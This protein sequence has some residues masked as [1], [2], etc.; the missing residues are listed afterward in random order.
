MIVGKAPVITRKSQQTPRP[1]MDCGEV[2]TPQRATQ[3]KFC[4]TDCKYRY[5]RRN[6]RGIKQGYIW[7][8]PDV[9]KYPDPMQYPGVA[10]DGRILEH[11]FIMQ[12]YLGRSL[13]EI[14]TIHHLN[15]QK[16]DNRIENLE[17]RIGNHGKGWINQDGICPC[18]KRPL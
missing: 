13:L 10:N 11:R 9:D 14:E 18:C 2:F 16:D 7:I 1:C 4:C 17:L 8:Y 15:G 12:E 3:G 5:G 6:Y